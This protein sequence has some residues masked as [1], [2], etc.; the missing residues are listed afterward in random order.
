MTN[1]RTVVSF[2]LATMAGVC[3]TSGIAVLTGGRR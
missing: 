3:F 1:K 2:T